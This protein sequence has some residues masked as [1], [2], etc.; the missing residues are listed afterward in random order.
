L[1][2]TP[3]LG[4]EKGGVDMSPEIRINGE[5][6]ADV[7]DQT[8]VYQTLKGKCL[9]VNVDGI[10]PLN[11]VQQI[12]IHSDELRGKRKIQLSPGGRGRQQLRDDQQIEVT[13]RERPIRRSSGWKGSTSLQ[14]RTS[15]WKNPHWLLMEKR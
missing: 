1:W 13:L 6:F 5:L 11:E 9:Y 10:H 15:G 3:N 14:R 4:L 8:G 7:P 2:L 12:L